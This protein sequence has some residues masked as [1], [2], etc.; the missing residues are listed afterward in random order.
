MNNA[1]SSH[2]AG[3]SEIDFN[4]AALNGAVAPS[5]LQNAIMHDSIA[6]SSAEKS[7]GHIEAGHPTL[8]KSVK[9]IEYETLDVTNKAM[10]AMLKGWSE[11]LAREAE[12]VAL[13]KR[14]K[15]VAADPNAAGVLAEKARNSATQLAEEAYLQK[16]ENIDK[17]SDG[18]QVLLAAHYPAAV[19][20]E[21]TNLDPRYTY[22]VGLK[23]MVDNAVSQLQQ[24]SIVQAAGAV[25]ESEASSAKPSKVASEALTIAAV[26]VAG[27]MAIAAPAV[28]SG[29]L[30][31]SHVVLGTWNA[32]LPAAMTESASAAVGWFSAMWGTH[33]LYQNAGEK[34]EKYSTQKHSRQSDVDF[35]KTYAERL[36]GSLQVPEFN[37]LMLNLIAKAV[38]HSPEAKQM[39]PAHLTAMAKVALLSTALALLL[40]AEEGVANE[41]NFKGVLTGEVDLSKNDPYHS[42][43][44]KRMLSQQIHALLA[45]LPEAE[46]TSLLLNL[47][48]YMSQRPS[49]EKLLDQQALFYETLNPPQTEKEIAYRQ[50]SGG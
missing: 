40:K 34:L 44:I 8:A 23:V 27:S 49:V 10:M 7:V 11:S 32:M 46:R 6:S 25:S 24:S 3:G 45:I 20:L 26:I 36:A 2:A 17:G 31:E 12:I 5:I 16:I 33:Q 15:V 22:L 42:A 39:N 28:A 19:S 47:V 9:D 38:E 18:N 43:S 41:W 30:V 4:L 13:L 50:I 48:D 35:A 1:I 29:V 21:G 37:A 14:S